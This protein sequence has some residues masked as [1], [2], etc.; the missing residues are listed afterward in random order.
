[1]TL[2]AIVHSL[3]QARL[4]ISV[5]IAAGVGAR[6]SSPAGAAAYLGP[7]YWRAVDDA[8]RCDFPEADFS[9]VLDCG[10]DAAALMAAVQVRFPA[11]RFTGHPD[12]AARLAD[13]AAQAGT[14]MV[15]D[16]IP[17]LDLNSV[18]DPEAACREVIK[19]TR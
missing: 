14:E 3:D 1:V 18:D 7:G 19:I 4:A 6:L 15:T 10:E 11:V 13:I 5:A 8:I 9:L 16:P 2:C 17:T 12:A